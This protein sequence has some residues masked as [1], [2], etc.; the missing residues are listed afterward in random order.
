MTS[1]I[2][3]GGSLLV[4]CI[5]DAEEAVKQIPNKVKRDLA[6]NGARLFIINATKLAEEIGLGQRTNTIMQAAFFKLADIIPFEE[7]QQYMKDYAKKSYAKKGD[8]IVQMNYNAIDKG[9]E[10]LIEVLVDPAWADLPVEELK[11]AEECCSCG[12]G[13]EKSKTELFVERIAKPI[14]AIK[15][16][17]LPVSAFNGYEDGTFE[18][19]T[20]AFEKR[21]IAVHVPEWKAENCIQCNQCCLLYTSPSPRDCS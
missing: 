4:N 9:A 5:W 20:S 6:K 19:G 12:C 16:Y 3:K 18:N 10:G 14:N 7:A 8:D 21:G 17:D 1:G 15:G 11:P 2:R 13:H